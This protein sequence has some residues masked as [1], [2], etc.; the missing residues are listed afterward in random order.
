MEKIVFPVDANGGRRQSLWST[1]DFIYV[2]LRISVTGDAMAPTG[3]MFSTAAFLR[4][5]EE[6]GLMEAGQTQGS[7]TD[8][9]AQ[10]TLGRY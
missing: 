10:K 3:R 9:P 5:K 7:W 1:M 2:F 8:Q 6:E 4:E